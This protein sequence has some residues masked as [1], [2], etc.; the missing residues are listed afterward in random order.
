MFKSGDVVE[1]TVKERDIHIDAIAEF[2]FSVLRGTVQRSAH[3]DPPETV[4]L[5]TADLRFPVSVISLKN[6]VEV[7]GK[8]VNLEKTDS[9]TWEVKGSKGATYTVTRIG[10]DYTCNCV[11]FQYRKKCKHVDGVTK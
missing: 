10:S 11:G 2:K 7:S 9:Q 1:L 8:S 6:I 3:Y 5:F 4:R